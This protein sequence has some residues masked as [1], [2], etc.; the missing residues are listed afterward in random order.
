MMETE[1]SRKLEE[2]VVVSGCTR[3]ANGGG[4]RGYFW[5]DQGVILGWE[6]MLTK[7]CQLS[8]VR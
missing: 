5:T 8:V 4:E 3:S 2:R 7:R 1:T 6:E